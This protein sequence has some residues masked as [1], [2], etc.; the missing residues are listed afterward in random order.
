MVTPAR[1]FIWPLFA[2]RS[3]L[4]T[5]MSRKEHTCHVSLVCGGGLIPFEYLGL[6][7]NAVYM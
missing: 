1:C 3:L 6:T 7:G 2:I 4:W 5:G